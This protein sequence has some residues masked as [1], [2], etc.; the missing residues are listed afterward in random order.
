MVNVPTR[1]PDCDSHSPTPL[2]LFLSS[3][4]SIFSAVT[5]PKFE[6]SDHIGISVS[7][8]VLSNSKGDTTFHC[9]AYSY[10]CADWDG[11]RDH[12]RKISLNLVLLLLLLNFVSGSR[13]ELLYISLI[14]NIRSSLILSMV[15]NCLCCCYIS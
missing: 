12:L 7:I 11:L 8:D 5:F 9:T 1:I 10:S 13:L 3:D 2:G 6:N 14:V 4:A 15:F